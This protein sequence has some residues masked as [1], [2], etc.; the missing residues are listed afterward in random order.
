M[1]VFLVYVAAHG[2]DNLRANTTSRRAG[3]LKGHC[4]CAPL[5]ASGS[6]AMLVHTSLVCSFT[7]LRL[8]H[9]VSKHETGLQRWL[10]QHHMHCHGRTCYSCYTPMRHGQWPQA[11]SA[12]NSQVMIMDLV[13]YMQLVLSL[14]VRAGFSY[15]DGR[16]TPN[17][18][19]LPPEL[20]SS[21]A[22]GAEGLCCKQQHGNA[23]KRE[24]TIRLSRDVARTNI[25]QSARSAR[26][27]LCK[28]G[29]RY[30]PARLHGAFASL[31]GLDACSIA[32]Y[33]ECSLQ[34][35]SCSA[36]DLCCCQRAAM[37]TAAKHQSKCTALHSLTQIRRLR[38]IQHG[39]A[40][41]QRSS[42]WEQLCA[43]NW[44]AD[45]QIASDRSKALDDLAG[46]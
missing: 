13:A 46:T 35:G 41:L 44:N 19:W 42:P 10:V 4:R 20:P 45:A 18:R 33:V 3:S 23:S 7:L 27:A 38:A 28:E 12:L 31:A 14:H 25:C 5:V 30:I 1:R 6:S 43:D 17:G 8:N 22:A 34:Q 32:L 39:T 11:K 40:A 15:T 21:R 26:L 2:V 24:S 29:A 9:M 16:G 37:A 36:S